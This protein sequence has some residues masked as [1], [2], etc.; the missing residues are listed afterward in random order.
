MRVIFRIIGVCVVFMLIYAIQTNAAAIT[1]LTAQVSQP[2]PPASRSVRLGSSAPIQVTAGNGFS[3]A[4]LYDGSVKCWGINY[5]GQLGLGD[6][7]YRGDGAN[8]MGLNLPAV[9]LGTG[10]TATAIQSGL[11]HTCAILD[12]GSVKCWG[13]NDSGQL[14]LGDMENRGDGTNEMGDY[15]PTVDLG[16]DVLGVAHTAKKISVGFNHTCAILDDNTTKCWGPNY[17]GEL[18]LGDT[19]ARGDNT[20]EMGDSLPVVDLGTNPY[21]YAVTISA[22]K[23]HTCALLD[24][25]TVKCWGYNANGQLGYENNTSLGNSVNQMGASLLAVNVGDNPTVTGIFAGKSF[26]CVTLNNATSKCW[27]NSDVGQLGC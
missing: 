20:G 3:C 13:L 16:T 21:R 18:G 5:D 14:G 26:T 15:L 8:E 25:A 2:A 24:N 10:R 27:G 23:L 4:L 9:N 17:F 1:Q 11:N 22:G 6:M 19:Q 12:N 7:N